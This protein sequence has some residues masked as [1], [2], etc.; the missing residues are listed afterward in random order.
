MNLI[1]TLVKGSLINRVNNNHRLSIAA[2][3]SSNHQEEQNL[4]FNPGY[5][6]GVVKQRTTRLTGWAGLHIAR[7]NPDLD[8]YHFV[9]LSKWMIIFIAMHLKAVITF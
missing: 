5:V 4:T 7:A 9:V 8:N 6:A 3:G 1:Y 2:A